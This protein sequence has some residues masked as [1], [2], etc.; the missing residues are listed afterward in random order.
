[1]AGQRLILGSASP[2]RLQ[3]LSILGITPDQVIAADINEDAHKGELP[4]PYVQRIAF[5]KN[6][7]LKD[8]A[9]DAYLLTSDTLVA[10]GRRLL[11]KPADENE[12]RQFLDLLSGRAHKVMT[13]VVLRAP[14]GRVS[15]RISTTR[16]QVKRLSSLEIDDYIA[17][18]DWKGKAGGYAI[19]GRFQA[20]IRQITGSESGVV[21]LPLYETAQMLTGLGY[22]WHNSGHSK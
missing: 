19:Q 22:Q 14:D 20:Y 18:S 17:S 13:A 7:A 1:M 3:L 10:V 15:Q 4:R 16:V 12:A 2:R 11:M 9:K 5:E 21:G 8:Q 6:E